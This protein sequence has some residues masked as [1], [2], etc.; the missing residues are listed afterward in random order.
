MIFRINID[1]D[2][3][4]PRMGRDRIQYIGWY[5]G[6]HVMQIWEHL[7]EQGVVSEPI[8]GGPSLTFS[9]PIDA[10]SK[11]LVCLAYYADRIGLVDG[12][13]VNIDSDGDELR[14][15]KESV[16]GWHFEI[17]PPCRSR[18]TIEIRWGGEEG[19]SVQVLPWWRVLLEFP[20]ENDTA[21]WV[22]MFAIDAATP[23]TIADCIG[24]DG[25][26]GAVIMLPA[27][28][29]VSLEPEPEGSAAETIDLT[30]TWSGILPAMLEIHRTLSGKV[31]PSPDEAAA[32]ADIRREFSRMARA[33][34]AFN[35]ENLNP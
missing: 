12:I 15:G 13:A 21:V 11:A 6:E 29:W 3:I 34:D 24:P 32:L 30:P 16:D 25:N 1:T 35:Q 26:M 2:R 9:G 22:G 20:I 7:V 31:N 17:A 8:E 27:S 10:L 18:Q 4:P 28:D 14:Y 33:A 23:V 19:D 5:G